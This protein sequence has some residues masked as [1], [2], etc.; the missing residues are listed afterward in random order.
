MQTFIESKRLAEA[1]MLER[2]QATIGQ[3][4]ARTAVS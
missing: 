1:K 4:D 2:Q 3:H